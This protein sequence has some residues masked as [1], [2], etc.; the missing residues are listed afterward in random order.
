MA[1]R[2]H[3]RRRNQRAGEG[4]LRCRNDEGSR[5]TNCRGHDEASTT[6]VTTA[7]EFGETS[8]KETSPLLSAERPTVDGIETAG[9]SEECNEFGAR[10][11]KPARLLFVKPG[12]VKGDHVANVKVCKQ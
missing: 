7:D 10:K 6:E 8:T 11:L 9:N 5:K 4:T 12:I 3:S 1:K 2:H